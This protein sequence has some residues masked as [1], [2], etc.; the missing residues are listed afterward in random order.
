[1]HRTPAVRVTLGAL[2]LGAAAVHFA[3]TPQHTRESIALGIAFVV[4]AWAQVAVAG[5]LLFRPGR[6]VLKWGAAVQIAVVAAWGASRTFGLPIG[7]DRWRAEAVGT[8]DLICVG[9]E[10]AFVVLT[11]VAL[12]SN[13]RVPLLAGLVAASLVMGGTSAA[14][15]TPSVIDHDHDDHEEMADGQHSDA[16]GTTESAADD[17]AHVEL[18][19]AHADSH[20]VTSTEPP[21]AEQIARANELIEATKASIPKWADPEAA[22]AA[23]FRSIQG[24][25][26]T[27]VHFVNFGWMLDDVVLDPEH[28]ESL[29]YRSTDGTTDGYELESAMYILP[30]IGYPIPDVGGSL[31]PWHNH[32][33]LC[34][35]MDG[36]IVGT[37][38]AGECPDGSS[39]VKTPDMLHVWIVDHADGPFGGLEAD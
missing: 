33:D 35:R 12:T 13:R 19:G 29:V 36:M 6:A 10:L 24:P 4:A 28:P 8:A 25:D 17:A 9:F 38:A 34:F 20:I 27:F 26:S 1:V 2:S 7:P 37:T 5:W 30:G 39:N 23:G 15:A 16:H 14:L 18:E 11:V 31:T 3:M 21:T 22:K 32:G